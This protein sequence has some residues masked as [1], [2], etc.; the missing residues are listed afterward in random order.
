MLLIRDEERKDY[1]WI[2][3]EKVVLIKKVRFLIKG[4]CNSFRKVGIVG[5]VR[6]SMR[7]SVEASRRAIEKSKRPVFLEYE[8]P[9]LGGIQSKDGWPASEELLDCL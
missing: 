9:S 8:G 7:F 6:G 2:D 1:E 3:R 4:G 5:G